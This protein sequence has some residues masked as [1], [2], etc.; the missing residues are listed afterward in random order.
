[1]IKKLKIAKIASLTGHTGSVYSLEETGHSNT[2]YSGSSDKVVA[3]WDVDSPGDGTLLARSSDIIYSLKFV[4]ER[5]ILLVGQSG[6]GIHVV[7]LE[8][9]TEERLLQYHHA[10]VFDLAFSFKH[11]LLFSLSGN[12]ELG[13]LNAIDFSLENKLI[14]GKG[15][16]RSVALNHDET[17]LAIGAA[18]G[19]IFTFSLPGMQP[20]KHFQAHQIGFSVNALC[21]SPDGNYLLS[22]SR[23]AHLNIF[24]VKN[25]FHLFKSVPAH[26][27]AIYSIAYSPDKKYFATGSRDKTIKIWDA[28][29]FDVLVRID[30]TNNDGHVNSVNKILWH[31]NSGHLI[32]ASDD[33][34]VMVWN[35]ECIN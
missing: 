32:S 7:N 14:L 18:D 35:I 20:L 19:S 11:G 6:G 12:G 33:R 16:L 2:F 15:K 22:G 34:S 30:K 3:Q 10:A 31:K 29:S 26:N 23:D 8:T 4:E 27:Y 24:E 25:D 13:M 17:V 1:M 9:R 21:F 5:G 28:N